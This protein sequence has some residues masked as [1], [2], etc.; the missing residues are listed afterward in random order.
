MAQQDHNIE[1]TSVSIKRKKPRK[2]KF[3]RKKSN[4]PSP[5]VMPQKM[6]SLNRNLS[7]SHKVKQLSRSELIEMN[8]PNNLHYLITNLVSPFCLKTLR[9]DADLRSLDG[10]IRIPQV[11]SLCDNTNETIQTIKKIIYAF[12]VEIPRAIVFDYADCVRI[13]IE[14]QAL[15]DVILMEYKVFLNKC[16]SLTS[17]KAIREF[18]ISFGGRN[19]NN[20]SLKK[21]MFSVGSPANLGIRQ[22]DYPDI[23]KYPMCSHKAITENDRKELKARK[24]LDTSL[25]IDYVI[26]C[27]KKM[28]KK[29][30]PKKRS[31]LCTV[32]GEILINAEEHSTLHH[33][34]SMGYFHETYE[35]EKHTGLFHL[36]ILN[37]GSSIYE[38]FS[39]NEDCPSEIVD[40]MRALSE[41]Y[42]RRLLFKS[43]E[44]EEETLWTLYAL[45]QGV[46]SVPDMQR[47]SGTIQ[48]IRSFFNI[49]GSQEVDNVSRMVLLSGKTK[50]IFDGSYMVQEK[51]D[52][53]NKFNVMTFN[54]SGN[55]EDLPNP[56]FVKTIDTFFPGTII[57]AKILLNEDDVK[58]IN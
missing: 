20:E 3:V 11:F 30:T 50:I 12:F 21:M 17:Q 47:G 41:K 37:F 32:I 38:K 45:Q 8:V 2:A 39:K 54:E 44:F 25:A 42:T 4:P 13:D 34:F 6:K 18:P 28:G 36:V 48:F 14:A 26:E 40:K 43:G 7:K 15:L 33:R 24:E 49:K 10:I 23:I 57:S 29:L 22:K 58:E 51:F 56:K 1:V 53:K 16:S 9:K 27:L 19:M 52:G 5:F 46:T 31:D 35:G 55:I